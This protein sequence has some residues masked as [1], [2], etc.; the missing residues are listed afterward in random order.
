M[1]WYYGGFQTQ[2]DTVVFVSGDGDIFGITVPTL[3]RNGAQ[4]GMKQVQQCKS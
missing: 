2:L 4:T 3:W 1:R